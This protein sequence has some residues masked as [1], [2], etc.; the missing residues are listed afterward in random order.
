MGGGFLTFKG[1]E[2]LGSNPA[3]KTAAAT[4][5]DRKQFRLLLNYFGVCY[6]YKNVVFW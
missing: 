6:S 2:D 3:T 4:W 1:R 5:R